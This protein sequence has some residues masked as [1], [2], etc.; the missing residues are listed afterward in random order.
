MFK[1]ILGHHREGFI[2]K[3]RMRAHPDNEIEITQKKR[4]SRQKQRKNLKT[5]AQKRADIRCFT[6]IQPICKKKSQL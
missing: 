5:I 6:E 4:K 1:P 3:Q 2:K